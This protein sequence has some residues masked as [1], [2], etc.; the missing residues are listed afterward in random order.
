MYLETVNK[1]FDDVFHAKPTNIIRNTVGLAGYVYTVVFNDTKYVIKISDDKNLIIGSTYWL[2]KVKDLDIPTP[3]VIAENLVNA[4]YYFV[5]SFIP[6]KDLG[7]IYSSLLKSEKKIIAKKIIG[8]QKEIKKLPMAKGFGSLNSYEDS[9]NICSS[10]EESLLNDI[11]RAEE[12]IIKNGIFSVEY[13]LK[14]K[15]IVPYFKEYFNSIKPEPFLDD[16]TT[17]NV[18]IHEGKLSGIIDLDWI[19]FGDEVL[20]LGLVTMALL[21]MKA[22]LDYADYLKDEMNLNEKQERVLKF[23]VL[24][25][26]VIFMS[27]KGMCFNQAEPM[28]V[29]EEEK[30]LLQEIFNRYYEELEL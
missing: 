12:G 17:K 20:F 28:K 16:I 8:F 9:E 22:D 14:L 27:E 26:C 3:C 5:M 29:S 6:G 23:Y 25:F 30:M 2:N 13:V 7:L 10:W 18:L 1:I 11:N 21:S 4:P 15:K 19:S 24:M